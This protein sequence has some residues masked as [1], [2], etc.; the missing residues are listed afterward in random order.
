MSQFKLRS[1]MAAGFA[2]ALWML[3]LAGCSSS[4]PTPESAAL[5]RTELTFDINKCQQL[6]AT[7]LYKCPAIDK[8]ICNPDYTGTDIQC[9]RINKNGTVVV[10]QMQGE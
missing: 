2:S 1:A 5:K 8:P 3:S 7:G 10:Q 4:T 9:V 6:G